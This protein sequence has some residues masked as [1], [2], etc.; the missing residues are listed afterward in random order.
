MI[1]IL[2]LEPTKISKDFKGKYVLIYGDPKIGKTTFVSQIPK[3]LIFAFE[4]GYNALNNKFVQPITSWKD[5]K[6][7][8][9]QLE[10]PKAK[11][12]YD[13]CAFD[14]L[15]I[16]YELC[17]QYICLQNGWTNISD[18]AWGK[19]YDLLKKEFSSLF[20]RVSA[21]GYGIAFIS[22]STE[23]VLKDK[24][25]QEYTQMQPAA[26]TRAKDIANKLVDFIIYIGGIPNEETGELSRYMQMRGTK[27]VM[28]GSR[29]PKTP[30]K[31]PLNYKIFIDTI[32][33]AIE[34]Q[35]NEEGGE[36]TDNQ[37]NFYA[38]DKRPFTEVFNEAKEIWSNIANKS[39][40][41][42][43]YADLDEIITKYF[44][45]PIKLST[46]NESQQDLLELT[47]EDLKDYYNK[48]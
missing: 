10:N 26:P 47:I 7:A 45:Q 2:N 17:E 29:F 3:V 38:Q 44:G 16:A 14:T 25:G 39:S 11:E 9:K 19:G 42:K 30:E 12:K 13:F 43:V 34:A 5:L 27:N 32:A 36:L 18:G 20:R 22:H 40:D 4:P 33:E 48:M 31:I 23:K 15:D 24:N 46:V 28:A 41:D 35:I 21:A 6:I 1:D 8:V 37:N